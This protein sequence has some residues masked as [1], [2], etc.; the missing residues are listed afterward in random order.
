M[1]HTVRD[2]LLARALGKSWREA[3]Q[4]SAGN[5]ALMRVAPLVLPSMRQGGLDFL[6][7]VVLGAAITHNDSAAVSSCV[8]YAVMLRELLVMDGPP[9]PCWWVDRF[10]DLAAAVE[11]EKE[12]TSRAPVCADF[13]GGLSEFVRE[14]VGR[15]VDDRTPVLEAC[16]RWFSGAYLLE[17]VPSVLLILARHATDPEEAIV[18]A[19]ND[20]VDNDTIAAIVGMAV[21]ALHGRGNL[22]RRWIDG[23]LGRTGSKD[24]GAVFE[25]V[26]RALGFVAEQITAP[27]RG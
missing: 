23:L 7:D 20:T 16:E 6:S 11:T 22:P 25:L 15:A 17:T 13:R 10:C 8:A 21:G 14:E 5:G 9:G 27:Q 2:F 26:E 24:D 4:E 18:R 3:G 12:Y 19:V 1:G